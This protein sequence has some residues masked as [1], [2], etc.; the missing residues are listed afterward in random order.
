MINF[1]NVTNRI[2]TEQNLKKSVTGSKNSVRDKEIFAVFKNNLS[3]I[4]ANL[5]KYQANQQCAN[6][7]LKMRHTLSHVKKLIAPFFSKLASLNQKTTTKLT[8][9]RVIRK[10]KDIY[11]YLN[12]CDFK[13]I[14][15]SEEAI[16]KSSSEESLEE[17]ERAYQKFLKD[18]KE[19]SKEELLKATI[20]LMTLISQLDFQP[21]KY[22]IRN[23]MVAEVLT[24]Y[25]VPQQLKEGL[26]IPFSCFSEEKP[27]VVNYQ[28]V[29]TL[30]LGSTHIPV[31]VFIPTEAKDQLVHPPLLIFRGTVFNLSNAVDARSVI[32]NMNKIGPARIA[33]DEFKN[34]L[35]QFFGKWF[36]KD[37]EGPLFRIM[38]YSQGGVLGQ[39]AVVDFYP[40]V[41]RKKLNESIFLHSPAPEEA[42]FKMWT[43][44]PDQAKPTVVN[45]IFRRDVVSKRGHKFIGTTYEMKPKECTFLRA[46][47]GAKFITPN[48]ELFALDNEKESSS[49]TR[50]LV[51]QLMSS[52]TVEGLYKLASKRLKNVAQDPFKHRVAPMS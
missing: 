9:N 36:A 31:Y 32:E 12:H 49:P 37:Q 28:L 22:E 51:N 24:K 44:I 26:K 25:L 46:H 47:L 52:G 3:H 2:Q 10:L 5:E 21:E 43:E 38:G 15:Q 35:T 11:D 23:A 40:F 50:R 33:Y 34:Q 7:V 13:Y 4:L 1:S 14:L 16:A 19:M 20:D 17:I 45:Y 27:V 48:W 41:Q 39:R 42:Y 6:H 29:K 8:E 30:S 18:K